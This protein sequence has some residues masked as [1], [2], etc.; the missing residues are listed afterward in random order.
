M[1]GNIIKEIF[2]FALLIMVIVFTLGMLFYDYIPT[3][4][5]ISQSPAYISGGDMESVKKEIEA[6]YT[7][8]SET[9]NSPD[10]SYVIDESALKTFASKRE[11]V[12][13]TKENPFHNE[14]T[15]KNVKFGYDSEELNEK[16]RKAV[17]VLERTGGT[18][19]VTT[20]NTTTTNTSTS[21][22]GTYFEK[23]SNL[24]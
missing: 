2:V 1:G 7:L 11:Y 23:N 13:G 3:G 6:D 15:Y 8:D 12:S 14:Y 9:L 17:E 5:K 21:S 18:T 24:K 10:W 22:N 20:S 19:T 16:A 4:E